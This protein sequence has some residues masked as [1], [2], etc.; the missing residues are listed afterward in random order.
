MFSEKTDFLIHRLLAVLNNFALKVKL[1]SDQASESMKQIDKL[2]LPLAQ[3]STASVAY[4]SGCSCL[5]SW[6]SCSGPPA[7][8]AGRTALR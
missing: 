5:Q 1:H 2:D 3:S 7:Y 8:L 6:L 4:S